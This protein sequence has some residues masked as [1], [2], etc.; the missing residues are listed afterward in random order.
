MH[1]D[2]EMKSDPPNPLKP[3]QNPL[4]FVGFSRLDNFLTLW[5]SEF[6]FGMVAYYDDPLCIFLKKWNLNQLKDWHGDLVAC[7][8]TKGPFRRRLH[9]WIFLL[10]FF[11]PFFFFLPFI[12]S[13]FISSSFSS[14]FFFAH[15]R[16]IGNFEAETFIRP[17]LPFAGW[18]SKLSGSL[19]SS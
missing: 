4:F 12:V 11:L 1:I 7:A 15:R 6:K 5:A 10:Y 13:L 16:G 9:F 18:S 17:F 3:P 2:Q 19:E 14:S 8:Q